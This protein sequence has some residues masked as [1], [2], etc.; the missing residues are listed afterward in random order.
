MPRMK[1]KVWERVRGGGGG[2]GLFYAHACMCGIKEERP[3]LASGEVFFY[4]VGIYGKARCVRGGP[5][6][7][8]GR[9]KGGLKFPP[10]T[11]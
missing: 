1:K 3:P 9:R 10:H 7:E 2:G 4:W 11:S 8:H 5:I 6:S